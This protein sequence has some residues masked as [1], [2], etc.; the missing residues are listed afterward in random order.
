MKWEVTLSHGWQIWLY[1]PVEINIWLNR[2]RLLV[3]VDIGDESLTQ[4]FRSF[5]DQLNLR[6]SSN[7]CLET[8]LIYPTSSS[9]VRRWSQ[10]NIVNP[11]IPTYWNMSGHDGGGGR[12]TYNCLAPIESLRIRKHKNISRWLTCL[13]SPGERRL[14]FLLTLLVENDP[15]VDEASNP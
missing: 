14:S 4:A 3:L 11:A 10:I 6:M 12:T 13:R 5:P 1:L 7:L 2:I 9:I 15:F 8:S